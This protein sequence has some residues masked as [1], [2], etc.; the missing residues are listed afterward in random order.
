MKPKKMKEAINEEPAPEKKKRIRKR[1][2]KDKELE[3]HEAEWF[4]W[5]KHQKNPLIKKGKKS[6]S[7]LRTIFFILSL[8]KS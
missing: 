1:K 7:G 6:L 2:N 4:Y 5:N 8:I 3:Q